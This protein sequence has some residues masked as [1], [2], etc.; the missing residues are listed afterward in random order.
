MT[1]I[2]IV[3]ERG[4]GTRARV[5]PITDE[6]KAWIFENMKTSFK[7]EVVSINAESAEDLEVDIKAQ[8]LEVEVK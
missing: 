3:K 2:I 8:G 4:R 6:G 5:I 1:D 7:E